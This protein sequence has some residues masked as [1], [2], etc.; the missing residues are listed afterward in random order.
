[1]DVMTSLET[2]FFGVLE[3]TRGDACI[4]GLG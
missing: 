1:L 3:A 2:S 4:T